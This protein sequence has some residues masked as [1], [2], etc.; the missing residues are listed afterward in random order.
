[1]VIV[2]S[3]LG[4]SSNPAQGLTRA[5]GTYFTRPLAQGELNAEQSSVLG[6]NPINPGLQLSVLWRT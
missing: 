6:G 3:L 4:S 5:S 1:M 2:L